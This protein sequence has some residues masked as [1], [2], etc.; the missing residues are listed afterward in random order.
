MAWDTGH[1][2]YPRNKIVALGRHWEAGVRYNRLSSK[3][4]SGRGVQSSHFARCCVSVRVCVRGGMLSV[5]SVYIV[6]ESA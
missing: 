1:I 2:E 4:T 3:R 6:I 5:F